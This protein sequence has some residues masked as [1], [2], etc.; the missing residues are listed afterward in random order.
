MNKFLKRALILTLCVAMLLPLVSAF[1]ANDTKASSS[2]ALLSIKP[3][4]VTVAKKN[5]YT[6]KKQ[7]A[8]VKVVLE[9]KTLKE[10]TDYVVTGNV[11]S[12]KTVGSYTLK[13]KVSGTGRYTGTVKKTVTFKITKAAQNVTAKTTEFTVKASALKKKSLTVNPGFSGNK[14]DMASPSAPAGITINRKTGALVLPKGL[15]KG[16]YK[17]KVYTPGGTNF[18]AGARFTITIHVK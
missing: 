14:T 8:E 18:K 13:V 7:A 11:T 5:A 6:G 9:G 4:T 1:A 10:G 17:V 2:A 3:A 16:N 12:K 15:K